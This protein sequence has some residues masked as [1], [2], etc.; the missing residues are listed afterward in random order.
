M[1]RRVWSRRHAKP[2]DFIPLALVI[3]PHRARRQI[4]Q[5]PPERLQKWLAAA[6]LASRRQAEQ[7]IRVGRLTVNG[8]PARL[9]QRVAAGDDVR[10][11]GRPVRLAPRPSGGTA[12]PAFLLHRSPGEALSDGMFERLPRRAGRRFVAVSPMPRIDGGLELATADGALAAQLQRRVHGLASEFSARVR[13][14]LDETRLEAVRGGELDDGGRIEV[15][16]VA[17][18]EA[19]ELASNRWYHLV[20]RGASGKQVRQLLERQGAVVSR[21]LRVAIGPVRLSRDLARGHFRM[22]TA[23]EIAS[24]TGVG[25]S[26][27]SLPARAVSP[28]SRKRGPSRRVPRRPAAPG[29]VRSATPGAAAS[30][31][32]PTD[33]PG[34]ASR[35]VRGRG[36]VS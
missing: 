20:V 11:D 28:D 23:D 30:R 26:E 29:T 12:P 35:S 4:P 13:G 14:A 25:S 15:L 33:R 17:P 5:P 18:G 10:L 16:E 24:L 3:V 34:G 36:S 6:G 22:L 1:R 8:E 31:G 27:P 19:D 7:W 21:V 32:P 9:G 2:T